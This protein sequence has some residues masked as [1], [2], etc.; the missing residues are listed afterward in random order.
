M[1]A[2]LAASWSDLD[3]LWQM[4]RWKR[5][6]LLTLVQ[7]ALKDD[8]RTGDCPKLSPDS[9]THARTAR[10]SHCPSQPLQGTTSNWR[11]SFNVE[12]EADAWDRA[13]AVLLTRPGTS[14]SVREFAQR[15]GYQWNYQQGHRPI[16]QLL[17]QDWRGL[18]YMPGFGAKT[19]RIL[20]EIACRA[21]GLWEETPIGEGLPHAVTI[22]TPAKVPTGVIPKCVMRQMLFGPVFLAFLVQSRRRERLPSVW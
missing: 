9:T 7:T 2:V 18:G 5:K 4:Q 6:A 14:E 20:L 8:V 13:R 19:T 17:E 15:V 10:K 1:Q 11:H 12:C 16:R 21:A 22:P 3:E